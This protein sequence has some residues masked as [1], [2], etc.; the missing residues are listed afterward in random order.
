M[1]D[2]LDIHTRWRAYTG[3]K[4]SGVIWLE[5]IPS[6][7]D[8]TSI[9]LMLTIPITDG[10]HETPQFIDDGVPFVSAEAVYGGRVNFQHARYIDEELAEEYSKK[11]N[12]QQGDILLV[13]SGSTTG[14]VAIVDTPIR[15]AIWSPLALLR[16]NDDRYDANYIYYAI[17]SDYFYH[18]VR[19]RASI[20]TQPNIGMGVIG[21]LIIT[22]PDNLEEQRAIATF[23]DRETAKLDDLI[24][25]KRTFIERLKE[26]RSALISQAVTRGLNPDATMKD[27]GIAWL[28]DIPA[29]WNAVK[30]KW[31]FDTTS[32][33]TPNS[34]EAELYYGG[35]IPWLRTTDL[36]NDEIF[37]YEVGI[38][39]QA[40]KDTACSIVP[41]G[42]VL[43]A[44]YGGAGT[45]GKNALLRFESSINQAICAIFPNPRFSSEYLWR[46]MQMQRPFWMFFADGT[47]RDPNISQSVIND[48]IVLMPPLRE[49]IAIANYL[50]EETAKIDKLVDKTQATIDT[51]TEYRTALISAAVT[52]AIDVRDEV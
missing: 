22:F 52:G 17:N 35:A 46:F 25:T 36:N 14:K 3:Y 27:S 30:L 5:Q 16:F 20:S 26:Q 10:P 29:H 12:P 7:W 24:S 13:K 19:Q 1:S 44:M 8:R 11:A 18:Q 41:E 42:A 34:G 49:Q 31:L 32:G 38:T 15:F 47:R 33:A 23:L 40:L 39:E 43:V 28:G 45:I 51:L 6:H 37:S 2:T 48:S 9:S 4:D 21:Q 50:D